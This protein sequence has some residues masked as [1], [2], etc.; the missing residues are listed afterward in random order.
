MSVIFC[1]RGR[2]VGD[3]WVQLKYVGVFFHDG[4]K[5]YYQFCNVGCFMKLCAYV[6]CWPCVASPRH[7]MESDLYPLIELIY[8]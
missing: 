6:L 1:G 4:G 3:A 2:K 8:F 5:S 7:L